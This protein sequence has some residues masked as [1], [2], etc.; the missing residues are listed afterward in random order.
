MV[1]RLIKRRTPVLLLGLIIPNI[2][3]LMAQQISARIG[4][5][6]IQQTIKQADIPSL[7]FTVMVG[8]SVFIVA[9]AFWGIGKMIMNKTSTSIECEMKDEI[10]NK[11]LRSEYKSIV[12]KETGELY[13]NFNQDIHAA[14]SMFT[15]DLYGMVHSVIMGVGITILIMLRNFIVAVIVLAIVLSVII[16]NAFYLDKFRKLEIKERS[17]REEGID[18][19]SQIL[20]AKS[21]IRVLGLQKVSHE[22]YKSYNERY[23][24]T[25]QAQNKL[26]CG[27][28]LKLDWFVYSCGTM[29]LPVSCLMVS[30][31]KIELTDVIYIIQL[32][33]NIIWSTSN[34]G[35]TWIRFNQKKVALSSLN[36]LMQTPEEAQ[37]DGKLIEA[38]GDTALSF[39][40]VAI[41]YKDYTAIKNI[42][43]LCKKGT[44]TAITG[45]SGIGKSSIINAILGFADHTGTIKVW[46][47]KVSE[48][49]YKAVRAAIAYM[50]EICEMDDSSVEDAIRFGRQDISEDRITSYIQRFGLNKVENAA[51]ASGGEKQRIAFI[52][53]LMKDCDIY[54]FDEPTAALDE[55]NEAL[56]LEYIS[57]LKEEGKTILI[58]THRQRTKEMADRIIELT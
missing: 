25:R 1:Q 9:Q 46:N 29:I 58:V 27:K 13:L 57:K 7:L 43:F 11:I 49:N 44:I 56:V 31:G 6:I 47:Q 8:I 52:R 35:T 3:A 19:L 54:I 26:E 53:T 10:C 20:N 34:L 33:G 22:E 30:M 38:A 2:A 40:D 51:S 28:A 5:N 55:H 4:E 39:E 37:Y 48:D 24:E 21:I 14:I 50:S 12:D 16:L 23:Y 42:N 36:Q 32:T 45:R 18:L 41:Q 15:E 17:I